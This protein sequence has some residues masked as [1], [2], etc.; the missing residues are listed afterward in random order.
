MDG[1]AEFDGTTTTEI[2]LWELRFQQIQSLVSTR[3][4]ERVF[5]ETLTEQKHPTVRKQ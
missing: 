1:L 2:Y 3:T 5:A 4:L